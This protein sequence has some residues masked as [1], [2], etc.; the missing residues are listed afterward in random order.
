MKSSP[1]AG[2]IARLACAAL[3]CAATL[4]AA[5]AP[6]S[7]GGTAGGAASGPEKA[8]HL[9]QS[10]VREVRSDRGIDPENPISVFSFVF[11]RLP[12]KVTVYPT[13]NYFYFRFLHDGVR[14]A[15]NIRLDIVDRDKGAVHFAYFEAAT[16]W[17]EDGDSRYKVLG[18]DDGVVLTK[19][20]RLAYDL[21]FRGRT[22]RFDLVDLTGVRPPEHAVRKSE[23]YLGPVYDESGIEFFLMFDRE[24]KTFLY[25][26]NENKKVADRLSMLPAARDILIGRRTGFAYFRD[27]KA[28]RKILIGVHGSNVAGN[29]YFDGP[30]DQLP[31]NF[32]DRGI[33]R[34]SI[35]AAYPGI[36]DSIDDFGN[37]SGGEGRLLI[38]PYK[39]YSQPA[40]LAGISECANGARTEKDYYGCFQ[41]EE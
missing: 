18:S 40:E 1:M 20:G 6:P 36:E 3:V 33:F 34:E 16:A 19:K 22:V 7:H 32:L 13:E 30:F 9:N 15:G 25:V 14:W 31:D 17:M 35:K 37:F 10:Y 23:I 38:N 27:A 26:L 41:P 4:A 2:T 24:Y 11:S 12:G 21:A 39:V 5:G 8:L 28:G 29:T